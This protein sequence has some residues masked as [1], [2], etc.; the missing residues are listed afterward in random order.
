MRQGF[1]KGST[2]YVVFGKV[3]GYEGFGRKDTRNLKKG[4]K[5]GN[6]RFT[7]HGI[8]RDT[9]E[10]RIIF[11]YSIFLFPNHIIPPLPVPRSGGLW[12]GLAN[13][14]LKA[15]RI[16]EIECLNRRTTTIILAFL[17]AS[18]FHC[19]LEGQQGG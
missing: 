11:P 14:L 8:A 5:Y 13:G 18:A 19:W 2:F 4:F 15:S 1:P 9:R 17:V 16:L 6:K 7:K 3:P 12:N 10:H